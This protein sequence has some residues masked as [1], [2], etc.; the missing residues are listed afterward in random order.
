MGTLVLHHP[1]ALVMN[2]TWFS[3]RSEVKRD[4]QFSTA[5]ESV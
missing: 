4:G 5:V 3:H 2:Q 1:L